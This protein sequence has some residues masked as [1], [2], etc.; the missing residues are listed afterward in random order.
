MNAETSSVV[1]E[2][3]RVALTACI[4]LVC[5]LLA[6]LVIHDRL[7]KTLKL[8]LI[9]VMNATLASAVVDVH[10]WHDG[11]MRAA[12]AAAHDPIVRE[13]AERCVSAHECDALA[14]ALVPY[15]AASGLKHGRV[16]PI[17]Q[18]GAD[19]Q[20]A[21]VEREAFKPAPHTT[22]PIQV[23]VHALSSRANA[24]PLDVLAFEL[25]LAPLSEQ[26]SASR[27]GRSGETYVFDNRGRMLTLSR[28]VAASQQAG[29]IIEL[30]DPSSGSLTAMAERALAGE[31]GNDVIGYRDYRG[32]PVVGTWRWIPELQLGVATE[33]DVEDAFRTLSTL[34]RM[35]T[36]LAIAL[37]LA[38]A[39][40]FLAMRRA[41]DLRKRAE[42][43]ERR[44][45]QF[46]QY[47]IEAKVGEGGMGSVYL[48]RHALLRR[49]A[50]I[51]LLRPELVDAEALAR[52]EREAQITSA[53]THP[54]TVAIYDYGRTQEGTFYYAMEYLE[55]L[56]LQRLVTRFG[57][58][59]QARV[60]HFLR[61]ICGSLA[62]AHAAGIVHRDIKPANLL[63]C[64][65]GGVTDTLKVLD[66]GIVHLGA[67]DDGAE[68]IVLGTPE[69]MAPELFESATRAS[70]Q[71]DL[72][73]VG[74]VAY[75]LLTGAPPFSG[76][77]TTELGLAHLTQTPSAPSEVLGIA[78]D[79]TLEAAVL[80][81]L[82]KHP[83][84]RPSS[85]ASLRALLDRSVLANTWAQAD[86]EAWWAERTSELS[87]L[88]STRAPDSLRRSV[89]I[90]T[91]S[92]S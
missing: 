63:A 39:G 23:P 22:M 27:V 85:A 61:Q 44:A 30:R 70:A 16:R 56:D 11:A 52:F 32:V 60:L 78:C 57:A 67:I 29:K 76:G 86:A 45:E 50:A 28:F 42:H 7:E 55:G 65:R 36:G 80:A 33:L 79:P 91:P 48:A 13:R 69:Y 49:K 2:R 17:H 38:V 90:R 40:S 6:A 25:P 66:F 59:P 35:F 20:D 4:A 92:L 84:A 89:D 1:G 53:L 82:K 12:T 24:A 43:A 74:V 18:P 58:L 26:M 54:N 41:A 5:M 51:K 62:E 15:M 19:T 37:L 46:G 64:T 88:R 77:G 14:T 8:Q 9:A 75:Y 31:S 10:T 71:S 21:P 87:E 34:E 47:R 68:P 81:C 83:R 72:Y 3:N 73:S